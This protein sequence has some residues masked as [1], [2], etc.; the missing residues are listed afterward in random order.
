M[1]SPSG[2]ATQILLAAAKLLIVAL[3]VWF[4]WNRLSGSGED[5]RNAF[6][7]QVQR[8]FDAPSIALL[9]VLAVIN[10]FLEI[11]KWQTLASTI[12]SVS[13]WEATRQVLAALTLSVFTPNGIG[14]YGAKALFFK[15]V[16][17]RRVV[18]LNLICNGVQLIVTVVFGLCGLLVF[19][20]TF[21]T[22]E[23]RVIT[24][25]IALLTGLVAA[26][27]FARRITIKGYSIKTIWL[28]VREIPAE[29]HRRNSFFAVLRYLTFS[30][31]YYFM[32]VILGADQPYWLLMSIIASM[33]FIASALPTIQLFDFAVKG[34]VAVYFF[35][36]AGVSEW[37][38]AF[39]AT[40]MWVL[41]AALPVL[42]GTFF[43][44]S[45]KPSWKS[46]L[47]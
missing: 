22:G 6:F 2:K 32:F 18:F 44:L 13:F 45:F 35:G 41:N 19:T 7:L 26:L 27:Y 12:Q 39:V 20:V 46:S 9:L 36:M 24:L 29:N 42:V 37:I 34:G 11:L 38:P 8:N 47:R 23:I 21:K 16:F 1:Q 33:Y 10:R 15:R 5:E 31:Q 30:H 3:A 25:A 14:E 4:V 43:V 28:K 17:A 40:A